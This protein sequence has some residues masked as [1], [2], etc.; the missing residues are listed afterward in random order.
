MRRLLFTLLL[1]T[2]VSCG[3]PE[4]P[5]VEALE[6]V[7]QWSAGGAGDITGS[8]S[9]YPDR[10]VVKVTLENPCFRAAC[11]CIVCVVRCMLSRKGNSTTL[12]ARAGIF[13]FCSSVS[14]ATL[15]PP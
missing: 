15:R 10:L 3:T 12:S 5:E 14:I 2:L 9:D 6:V 8:G 7:P 13:T 1:A 4:V 11:S